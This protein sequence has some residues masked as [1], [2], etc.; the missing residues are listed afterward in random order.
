MDKFKK[1]LNS[2]IGV[3]LILPNVLAVIGVVPQDAVAGL[4]ENIGVIGT[5]LTS[6]VTA[7]GG[8]ILVFTGGEP[9]SIKN[10]V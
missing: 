6:L 7:V 10:V 9:L 8:I 4:V 2:V 5:A 3:L 1:I